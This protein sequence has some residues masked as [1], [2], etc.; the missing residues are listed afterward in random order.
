MCIAVTYPD[1]D[2]TK[3]PSNPQLMI[4]NRKSENPIIP[5]DTAPSYVKLT[6]FA[7]H[8]TYY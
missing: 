2:L 3:E 4:F 6:Y 1:S 5:N 7:S 8:I